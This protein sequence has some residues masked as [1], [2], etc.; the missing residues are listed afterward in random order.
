MKSVETISSG[1]ITA[2]SRTIQ[3]LAKN[4][5][6]PAETIARHLV[7]NK[8]ILNLQLANDAQRLAH[9]LGIT[10]EQDGKISLSRKGE[11]FLSETE[12]RSGVLLRRRLL[13]QLILSL[14]R[15]LMWMAFAGREELREKDLNLAQTLEE[16]G[17]LRRVLPQ[18]ATVFWDELRNAG[19][20]LDHA[21]LKKIGDDAEALSMEFERAR[22][23]QKGFPNL[24]Q[25]ISWVSRESDLHGYDILSFRG[26]GSNPNERVQIEVKKLS[27][28]S[29]GSLYFYFSRNEDQQLRAHGDSYYLHLWRN[30]SAESDKPLIV[31]G[32]EIAPRVPEDNPLGGSWSSCTIDVPLT[33][34]SSTA[35]K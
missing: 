4:P 30:L 22:L 29:D 15:D 33:M 21:M 17:L 27:S 18:D 34:F 26:E 7:Q 3:W 10:A 28:R 11:K 8:S 2:L 9:S 16:L 20:H 35:P 23:A 1:K 12:D 19:K 31:P 25:K 6:L 24:S 14:R 32:H 5:D 13:L